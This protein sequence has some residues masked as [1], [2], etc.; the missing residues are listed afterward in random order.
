MKVADSSRQAVVICGDGSFQ[1]SMNELAAVRTRNLDLKILLLD[2]GVLGLVRQIQNTPPYHGSFG[3]SLEGSRITPLL[4][5]PTGFPA[6]GQT[7]KPRWKTRWTASSIS[8]AAA[9]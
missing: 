1:M 8:R 7:G 2:N 9:C 3:V 4:P 5:Q 6:S